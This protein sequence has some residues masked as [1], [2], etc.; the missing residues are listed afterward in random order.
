MA[1][2]SDFPSRTS[3]L[4][5][6]GASNALRNPYRGLRLA[7]RWT[8]DSYYISSRIHSPLLEGIGGGKPDYSFA[9]RE[10]VE[11]GRKTEQCGVGIP[12]IVSEESSSQSS[13]QLKVA[14]AANREMEEAATLQR[15]CEAKISKNHCRKRSLNT[16]FDYIELS[17]GLGTTSLAMFFRRKSFD[18]STS[19]RPFSARRG[20]N[21]NIRKELRSISSSG[22]REKTLS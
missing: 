8:P 7:Q 1:L 20:I 6:A 9:P 4:I 14:Q 21:T 11:I 17:K 22:I 5:F 19:P 12:D 13:L 18:R 10:L 2:L 16:S 15:K 3:R